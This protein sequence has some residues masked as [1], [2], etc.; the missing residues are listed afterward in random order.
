M[1]KIE[2]VLQPDC[3]ADVGAALR[4]AKI[5][6]FQTSDVASFDP[7]AAPQG[8]YRG[9]Q[10]AIAR[11]RVKLEL[12]LPDHEVEPAIEAIREAIDAFGEGEAELVVLGLRDSVH[13]RPSPWTRARAAR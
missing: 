10:Y 3:L 11:G 9:A 2:V 1:H 4:R 5:G 6:P 8:S 7:A 13:L 12:I